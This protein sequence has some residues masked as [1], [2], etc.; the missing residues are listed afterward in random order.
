MSR[1]DAAIAS[2]RS[3]QA[4]YPDYDAGDWLTSV[5]GAFTAQ[6][7]LS[8]ARV[9]ADMAEWSLRG[10]QVTQEDLARKS[11]Y[12]QSQA[13]RAIALLSDRGYVM[14][15]RRP[16]RRRSWG[17]VQYPNSYR[18]VIPGGA[19]WDMPDT[20]R[21]DDGVGPED[22]SSYIVTPFSEDFREGQ[23][24][25]LPVSGITSFEEWL[26]RDESEMERHAITPWPEMTGERLSSAVAWLHEEEAA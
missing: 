14:V 16:A 25:R 3:H 1:V 24:G 12:S 9:L 17:Y 15:A 20:G 8:V 4:D 22:S 6:S 21:L 18:L 2:L 19:T 13:A 26:S 10:I 23:T 5:S 7:V 11:G